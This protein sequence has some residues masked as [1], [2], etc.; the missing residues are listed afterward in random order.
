[1]NLV[2]M[3]S[4]PD[5]LWSLSYKTR[6]RF[7]GSSSSISNENETGCVI[8]KESSDA[9]SLS[10]ASKTSFLPASAYF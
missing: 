4:S 6:V 7:F 1:M 5:F 2:W 8:P 10:K 9:T 3:L